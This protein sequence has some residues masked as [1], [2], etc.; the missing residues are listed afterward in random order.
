MKRKAQRAD[1]NDAK[2]NPLGVVLRGLRKKRGL[3]QEGLSFESGLDRTYISLLERGIRNPTLSTIQRLASA[4]HV[5][6]ARLV[7]LVEV[8]ATK[9]GSDAD[10]NR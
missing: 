8:A 1:A 10:E 3:S 9:G 2:D 6:S 5:S 4:L 7:H